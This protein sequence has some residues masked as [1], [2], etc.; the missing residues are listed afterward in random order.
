MSLHYLD[1]SCSDF[2]D[3]LINQEKEGRQGQEETRP[4][5]NKGYFSATNKAVFISF[6]CEWIFTRQTSLTAHFVLIQFARVP[7][8]TCFKLGARCDTPIVIFI[9]NLPKICKHSICE[10]TNLQRPIVWHKP[11]VRHKPMVVLRQVSVFLISKEL[12]FSE[13]LLL[14]NSHGLT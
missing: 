13:K 12:H 4:S 9:C 5:C 1:V 3:Y 7:V 2:C 6:L 11:M 10:T 8:T 14:T